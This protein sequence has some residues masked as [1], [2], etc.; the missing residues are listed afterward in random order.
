MVLLLLYSKTA[1][2]LSRKYIKKQNKTKKK[3]IT[4]CNILKSN[5]VYL[6]PAV[7]AH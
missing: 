6:R 3:K 2:T 7:L 1:Q 5:V 4:Y